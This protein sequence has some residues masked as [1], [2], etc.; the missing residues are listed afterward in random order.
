ML[1]GD[2][3]VVGYA[4]MTTTFPIM[5]QAKKVKIK[6]IAL[7]DKRI[8]IGGQVVSGLPVTDKVDLITMAV[9]NKITID[10]LVNFSYSSQPYQSFYPANNLLVAAS[11]QILSQI[12]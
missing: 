4:E 1:Y 11:E 12:K 3:V 8:L 7:K 5:P 6:L 10:N 2:Q 9:Q